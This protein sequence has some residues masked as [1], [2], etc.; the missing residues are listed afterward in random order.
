MKIAIEAFWLNTKELTGVGYYILNVFLEIDKQNPGNTYYMLY[1]G[2]RWIG[3]DL[4]SNFIP[5]CYGK[6][7]ATFA[8]LF[9]LHKTIK[10]L[11]PDIYH[12]PFPTRVPPQKLPCPIVTTVHDLLALHIEGFWKRTLFNLTTYWA[13]KK[14]SRFLCNSKYTAKEIIKYKGVD[15]SKIT[16][17]YLAPAHRVLVWNPPG[18]HL[19]FVGSLTHRKNPVFLAKVYYELCKKTNKEVLPLIFVGEDRDQG[20]ILKDYIVNCP[21]NGQIKWLSY[22]STEELSLLYQEAALMILPS[23]I[24]GFGMP[25]IEAMSA[26]LPVV[27]SDILVFRELVDNCSEIISGWFV[28]EWAQRIKSLIENHVYLEL[29]SSRGIMRASGFTWEVCAKLTYDTYLRVLSQQ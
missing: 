23:K 18:K 8:I 28:A 9:K 4:G 27:C 5:V 21:V 17:T 16:V 13:W 26:G 20:Q 11:K 29:L 25:V 7:R 3:P 22:I 19:L 2:E 6:G 12:A 15:D 1:T 14:T 24:E 10:Q